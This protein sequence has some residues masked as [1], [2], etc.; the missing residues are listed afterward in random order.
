MEKLEGV[1]DSSKPNLTVKID[2]V[3][4]SKTIFVTGFPGFIA[5]RLVARLARPDVQFYLLALPQFVSAAAESCGR[6]AKATTT[7]LENFAIVEGDISQNDLGISKEDLAEIREDTTDI[8]HLA[9]VYDLEVERDLA[10]RVNV[11]G[12]KNVN[13][14]ARSLPRLGR[15]NYVSTCY[16]AGLREGVI[17]ET[18]L[19]H[20]AGFRNF[21]EETKYLAETE[22]EKLKADLPVTIYRPA[23][24]V[25][26]SITGETVKF[27]GIYRLIFYL[28]KWPGLLRLFNVGNRTVK[29]NL[30]PVDFVVEAM[31][32]LSDEPDAVG[33][34]VALADPEPLTTAEIFDEVAKAFVGRGSLIAPPPNLVK[35]FLMSSLSPSVTGLPRSGVP[36]FYIPQSYDTSIAESLMQPRGIVCPRFSD[37]VTNL[38]EFVRGIDSGR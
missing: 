34:T 3:S 27:D 31:A 15:Y 36:Y 22:V 33:K 37:Y 7:P 8:F 29:L 14:F 26:D 9:A 23:V 25:G 1:A 10:Y 5:E 24:V 32:A 35:R 11:D 28:K 18:E 38:V 12:T 16:V 21:Y 6:I 20:T 2:G 19:E 30:V 4:F 13:E 17:L